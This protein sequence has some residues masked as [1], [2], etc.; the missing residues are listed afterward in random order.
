[1]TR[2]FPD[3]PI[4]YTT[5]N[6]YRRIFRQITQMD[7]SKYY[8]DVQ[9]LPD[10]D[11]ETV[12]E[13]NY[14]EHSV[15]VFID[16]ISALTIQHPLFQTL[17]DYAAAKM[18]STDREIGITILLSYDY[19]VLFYPLLCLYEQSPETVQSTHEYYTRLLFAIKGR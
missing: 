5:N 16:R 14:D 15:S 8:D 19:L 1:M 7:T 6:E 12:D 10:L 2:L 11:D 18:F 9:L 3:I 17:Y 4:F 13:Y